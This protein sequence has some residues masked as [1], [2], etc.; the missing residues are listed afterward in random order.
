MCR[1]LDHP[2]APDQPLDNFLIIDLASLFEVLS[3]A[4]VKNK[5]SGCSPGVKHLYVVFYGLNLNIILI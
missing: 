4:P 1:I 3:I 2:L 5:S